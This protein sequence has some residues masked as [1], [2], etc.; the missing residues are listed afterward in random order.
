MANATT[1]S[2]TRQRA[3]RGMREIAKVANVYEKLIPEQ[4]RQLQQ[5]PN[6]PDLILKLAES[7][8]LSNKYNEAVEQYEKLTMLQ[9][10]ESQWYKHL[11]DLYQHVAIEK[12]NTDEVI[13]DTALSLG[14]NLSYVEIK[15]SETI[16]NTTQQLTVSTWVKPT[17]F[18]NRYTPIIFKGDEWDDNF[19]KRSYLL[20]LMDTG[21]IQFSASPA[22]TPDVSIYSPAGSVKLNTWT[23]IAGVIDTKNDLQKLFINGV[24]VSRSHFKGKASIHKSRLPLRIGWTHEADHPWHAS[25]IGQIDDVRVWNIA[26]TESEIQSDMNT[27]LKGDEDG[28]VGYWKF[29]E[30]IEEKIADVSPN[31]NVG[32]T[33]GNVKLEQYTRPIIKSLQKG[34]D[35]KIY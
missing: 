4:L 14:G 25:F 27:Q 17:V 21:A 32:N 9:P 29:N 8:Q 35:G 23:H 15:D 13:E 30:I 16:D 24:E 28:L 7:Y 34:T 19:E 33:V 3:A 26:R 1:N 5:N 10:D 12:N 22:M 31:R 2:Y 18:P 11:G 6:D 20:N